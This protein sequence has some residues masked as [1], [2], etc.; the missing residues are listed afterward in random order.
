MGKNYSALKRAVPRSQIN[1]EIYQIKD[2]NKYYITKTGKV[3]VDYGNDLFCN[4]KTHVN[5]RNGYVYVTVRIGSK[6]KHFR[7]HKLVALTFIPNPNNLL[8]VGH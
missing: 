7:L 8:C 3:Y 5:D 6:P 1:E 4:I 2:T